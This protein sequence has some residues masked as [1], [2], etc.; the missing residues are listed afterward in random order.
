[1]ED[2]TRLAKLEQVRKDFI[3]NVSHELRTPIQLIK[4]FSETLLD[5]S[6][7]TDNKEQ[8]HRCM[9]IIH[10][11]ARTMENLTNDLLVL[12][13]LENN[14]NGHPGMEE[15][16]LAPLFAEAVSSVELQAEKQ[17][18]KITIDCPDDLKAM[19]HG[20]FIIQ[21]L[22]NLLDNGIKYSSK[23]SQIWA[24]AYRQNGEI[25]LEVKDQGKGIPAEHLGRIFERFYR[26]DR[27]HSRETGGTGLGLSI[28]RHIARIHNGTTEVESRTDKGSV[29][30]IRIAV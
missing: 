14:G 11:N 22:I 10:K 19:V 20:S 4:G 25:I 7:T 29:F 18:I 17:E 27:A 26:V 3:A 15:Q 23:K 24:S 16:Q 8:L 5:S 13:S 28:V 1:M 6:I 21:A 2:I 12:S 30:R 9:E